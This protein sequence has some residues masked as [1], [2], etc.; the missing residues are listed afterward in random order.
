MNSKANLILASRN[1]KS[2]ALVWILSQFLAWLSILKENPDND[3]ESIIRLWFYFA[4]RELNSIGRKK[5]LLVLSYSQTFF[6]AVYHNRMFPMENQA[7]KNTF[8]V[9]VLKKLSI[10]VAQCVHKKWIFVPKF[11]VT[12]ITTE[13]NLKWIYIF[14]S[15][16]EGNLIAFT[17]NVYWLGVPL[18]SFITPH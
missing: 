11:F 8:L 15:R 1:A 7:G 17:L 12:T 16:C 4:L 3:E 18:V 14:E 13:T 2:K 10:C 5:L 6:T 9:D